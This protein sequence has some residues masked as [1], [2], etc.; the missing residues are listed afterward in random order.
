MDKDDSRLVIETTLRQLERMR[1]M[2]YAYHAKFFQWLTLIFL[3]LL[4]LAIW[5]GNLGRA[6]LPFVVVSGGV[7]ASF[8]LHFCDFAR[9]HASMLEKKLNRLLPEPCLFA[10][11]CESIYFYPLDQPKLSGWVP[12]MPGRFFSAFTMHWTLLWTAAAG[13]GAAWAFTHFPEPDRWFYAGLILLWMAANVTYL[14]FYFL[15][16]KDL[17]TMEAHLESHLLKMNREDSHAGL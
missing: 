12:R 11:E 6:L 10:A 3:V 9:L 13:G 8:F 4:V 5:G 1:G 15:R 17:K 16:A 14:A 7:T 2:Q